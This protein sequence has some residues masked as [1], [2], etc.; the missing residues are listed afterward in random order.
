ME[1]GKPTELKLKAAGVALLIFDKG[2]QAKSSQK[3]LK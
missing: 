2:L 3:R 1:N